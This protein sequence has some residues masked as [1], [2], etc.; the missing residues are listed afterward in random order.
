MHTT[1]NKT[2]NHRDLLYIELYSVSCKGNKT[3]KEYVYICI[4]ES[5]CCPAEINTTL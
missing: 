4:T 2:D 1:I 3:E 5:L